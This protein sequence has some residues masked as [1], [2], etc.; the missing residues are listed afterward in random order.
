MM[1]DKDV[2]ERF[3]HAIGYGNLCGPQIKPPLPS[4][5]PRKP[6]WRVAFAKKVEVKRVLNLFL[7]FL[8]ERRTK[9]ALEALNEITN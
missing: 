9:K 4:G 7:P 5:N 2:V 8:G 1:P 6:C 3:I